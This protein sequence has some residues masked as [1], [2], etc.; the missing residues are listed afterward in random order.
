MSTLCFIFCPNVYL[1]GIMTFLNLLTL[2][3]YSL[4][5]AGNYILVVKIF[6]LVFIGNKHFWA[7]SDLW[8]SLHHE[9]SV[10]LLNALIFIHVLGWFSLTHILLDPEHFTTCRSSAGIQNKQGG[11]FKGWVICL[12]SLRRIEL[13]PGAVGSFLAL[14]TR[15]KLGAEKDLWDFV[16]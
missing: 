10:V 11:C 14:I 5:A 1:R 7:N 6:L 8:H 15:R 3:L 13:S 16:S 2:P 9:E 12:C 4:L